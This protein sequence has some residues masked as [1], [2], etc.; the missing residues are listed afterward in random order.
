MSNVITRVANFWV[1]W[2]ILLDNILLLAFYCCAIIFL[3]EF[4]EIWQVCFFP[5]FFVQQRQ[6]VPQNFRRQLSARLR[7]L[8]AQEKLEKVNQFF[9][10]MK[11]LNLKKLKLVSERYDDSFISLAHSRTQIP[12]DLE[13]EQVWTYFLVQKCITKKWRRS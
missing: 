6:E 9:S 8:V 7:R 11:F 13:R 3:Y 2:C 4:L 12:L 10:I 1:C 5:W